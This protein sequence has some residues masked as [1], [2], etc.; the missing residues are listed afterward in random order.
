MDLNAL[1]NNKMI[2][3]LLLS[4]GSGFSEGGVDKAVQ[5]VA[6][7][8][9]QSIQSK[10][11]ANMM[12]KMLAGDV[13]EGG[14]VTMDGKGLKLDLT[15]D[16]MS[17]LL[18]EDKNASGVAGQL[19][20]LGDFDFGEQDEET[21]P[22][23]SPFVSS[24]LGNLSYSDL[25]GLTPQDISTALGHVETAKS[26][27]QDEI[28]STVNN[29]YKT[30]L[31]QQALRIPETVEVKIGDQ[32]VGVSPNEALIHYAKMND[33]P[34]SYETFK[35]AQG[36]SEF[37]DYLKG[38]AKS[39]ATTINIGE[40]T[41]QKK[42]AEEKAKVLSADL[43][44][45]VREDLEKD[46]DIWYPNMDSAGMRELAEQGYS[47]MDSRRI[48]RQRAIVKEMDRRIKASYGA[49]K[50][51]RTNKGWKV[52]KRTIA[53]PYPK[54]FA[55]PKGKTY[56]FKGSEYTKEQIL[57]SAREQIS[58]YPKVKNRVMKRYKD[59]T[60]EDYPND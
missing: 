29:L 20:S 3:Q 6:G 42:G 55:K 43:L 45:N 51:K 30:A 32:V 40:R 59:I 35:I 37:M 12:S 44:P 10:N 49:D 36:D 48:I 54:A 16:A 21:Q 2:Q 17:G 1:A 14:K 53:N 8:G 50:V 25:A 58:K 33:L 23:T 27:S 56:T 9:M 26:M 57:E 60:G 34:L 4:A 22:G 38:M 39:K 46:D 19:G 52:G 11:F 41:L 24:Q 31:M 18:K 7:V 13:P 47:P 15:K 28:N 5:N